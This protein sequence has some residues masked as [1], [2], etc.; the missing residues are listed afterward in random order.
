MDN[1]ICTE[2]GFDVKAFAKA[3]KDKARDIA[4]TAKDVEFESGFWGV[5]HK[6]IAMKIRCP[7]CEKEFEWRE[8]K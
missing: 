6:I 4:G 1:V 7:N 3:N 2:C 5:T 8:V